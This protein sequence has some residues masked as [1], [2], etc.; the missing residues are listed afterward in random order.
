MKQNKLFILTVLIV[1]GVLNAAAQ[2][3]PYTREKEWANEINAFA[4]IDAKQTPPEKAILFTGSSSM[5]LWKTLREDF[6]NLKVIN[7]GFGGSHFED[8]NFFAP[9]IVLPYKPAKIVVYSGE[10][11]IEAGQ[12]AE[13]VLGDFK[14]FV[15]WRD[16]N[17]P[18][19]PIIY[20]SL[21]PSILRWAKWPE[22]RKAN[23]LIREEA[24]KH[25]RV[26][27][28]DLAS[29]M[30]GADGKP[31]P[32]IFVG[33]NLHMNAKGYAIWRENLGPRLK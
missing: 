23:N 24:K 33:D 27:F 17:L 11:D 14:E 22:M 3:A 26:T 32:D 12:S 30:L 16:K 8:L 28:A 15:A 19:T 6:P 20:V 9:K 29:K 31:L 18:G 4:E 21:K 1:A 7:R 2:S 13:N 25:R 5:R 10:N